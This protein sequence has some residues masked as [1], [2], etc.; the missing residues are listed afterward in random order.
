MLKLRLEA[1]F[2][3]VDRALKTSRALLSFWRR[4]SQTDSGFDDDHQTYHTLHSTNNDTASALG[5]RHHAENG[6]TAQR[7][8]SLK[9]LITRLFKL[10]LFRAA[11]QC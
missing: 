8:V 6:S 1:K 2:G 11:L 5:Q 10:V 7:L 3:R 4:S 9:T